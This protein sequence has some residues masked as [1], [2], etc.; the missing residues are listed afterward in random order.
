MAALG[1]LLAGAITTTTPRCSA[2]QTVR[3]P[4]PERMQGQVLDPGHCESRCWVSLDPG[5]PGKKQALVLDVGRFVRQLITPD[6]PMLSSPLSGSMCTWS[7]PA[8][9]SPA[10][11]M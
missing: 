8:A 6:D 10:L 4:H 1:V 11:I 9:A 2:R 5:R 7:P 3:R